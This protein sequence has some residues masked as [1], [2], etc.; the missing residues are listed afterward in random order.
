MVAPEGLLEEVQK[1]N[2]LLAEVDGPDPDWM[3]RWQDARAGLVRA[4]RDTVGPEA[5]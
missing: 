5:G 4:C 2:D 1:V 3:E